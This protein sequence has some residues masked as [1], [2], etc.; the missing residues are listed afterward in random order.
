M[1]DCIEAQVWGSN[2]DCADLKLKG[3]CATDSKI[4]SFLC[5][6]PD[7]V[8]RALDELDNFLTVSLLSFFII[9]SCHVN[10][11]TARRTFRSR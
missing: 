9:I 5:S 4:V 10:A 2:H 6:V 8:P 11:G 3:G 1:D 7:S